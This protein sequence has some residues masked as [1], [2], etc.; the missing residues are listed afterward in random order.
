MLKS[1][2]E[3]GTSCSVMPQ[4][5]LFLSSYEKIRKRLLKEESFDLLARLGSGAFSEIT[6]EVVSA[7]LVSITHQRCNEFSNFL[8]IDVSEL[9]S[10][11]SKRN[12]LREVIIKEINQ[13]TQLSN[14]DCRIIFD[15]IE[16]GSELS[17]FAETGT[18]MQTFDRPRFVAYHWERNKINSGWLPMQSTPEKCSQVSGMQQIVK[19][20][21]GEGELYDLMK[22]KE[23][24]GYS[25]GVWKAGS[26]FWGLKGIIHGVMG[27]LH[28]SIY[29]GYPYDTNTAV[30]IPK[31]ESLLNPIWAFSS[32]G[33]FS[34]SVRVLDKKMMVTNATFL[35]V[36]FDS[37]EWKKSIELDKSNCIPEPYSD[38]PT[39]WL[40]HGHPLHT[41]S[42]LQVAIARLMGYEW[43]AEND[44]EMELS[45][46]GQRKG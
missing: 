26:Q 27:N 32:S 7:I 9:P 14:P 17:K 1:N 24:D 41:E 11:Q 10:V 18:G 44:E 28:E 8:G 30:L 31:D 33:E 4:N 39:Q 23:E 20:E 34:K 22:S 15:E 21:K 29:L 36:Q 6:G 13:N 43:P 46:E 37:D 2:V 45:E 3:G 25:S 12:G 16:S 19:W 42:P 5:W 40:F 35:K 38:D